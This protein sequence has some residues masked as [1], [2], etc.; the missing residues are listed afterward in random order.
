MITLHVWSS[1]PQP[2]NNHSHGTKNPSAHAVD[3]KLT[4]ANPFKKNH[5]WSHH[6]TYRWSTQPIHPLINRSTVSNPPSTDP[7][8]PIQTQLADPRSTTHFSHSPLQPQPNHDPNTRP[9]H[10]Q[11]PKHW[12]QPQPTTPL[13][14]DHSQ[15]KKKPQPP[16]WPTPK[17]TT[18]ID[19]RRHPRPKKKKRATTE[20][21][22]WCLGLKKGE[23]RWRNKEGRERR[24]LK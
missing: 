10:N 3:L 20:K 17:T 12:T 18:T 21:E 16:Q 19:P 24:E 7:S 22:E 8:P 2:I 15:K 23:S 5:H 13:S 14:T 4:R 11:Q 6:R 9:N 1:V